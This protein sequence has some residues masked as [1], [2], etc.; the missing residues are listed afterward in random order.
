MK[1]VVVTGA[2][3]MIGVTLINYLL[4]K[5]IEVL[6]IVRENSKRKVN[7]PIDNN[8]KIIECN[9]NNLCNVEVKENYDT[10]FHLAWD[11]TIGNSRND[12]YKQNLNI[13]Y[14]LDAVNLA[15]KLG[16]TTFVGAGSQ[17][18]YGR[19]DGVISHNTH[20][21]PENG[22]GIAKLAA[23]TNEQNFSRKL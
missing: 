13:K 22:Y 18:E 23:R 19:V 4:N 10:F 2:T 1:R 12:L 16:C 9:L 17:A 11:G 20:T 21:N 5:D 6:A 8:L 15:N 7:L 3:G 14:T